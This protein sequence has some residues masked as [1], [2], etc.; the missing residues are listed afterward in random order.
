MEI[1]QLADIQFGY[2][3]RK[4]KPELF[5]LNGSHS[6]IQIKDI[7]ELGDLCTEQLSKITPGSNVKR[8]LV[9]KNDILFLSRG[10]KSIAITITKPLKNTLAS[11]YFYILR[12]DPKRVLPEYLAWFINQPST[13]AFFESTSQGSLMKTIPKSTFEELE[14]Q[15]PSLKIQ[16][17]IT[18]L[19]ALQKKEAVAMDHLIRSRK[20]L[21][22]GLALKAALQGN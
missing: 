4:R 13:Q 7:N 18:E 5:S 16:K 22:N 8:Y 15:L 19:D 1:G 21:I 3:V 2:Q 14:V 20:R 10:P 17:A 6:L 11:Y 12:T 9:T